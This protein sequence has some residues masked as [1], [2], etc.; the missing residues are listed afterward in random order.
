MQ[1]KLEQFS[2]T[3]STHSTPG[4]LSSKTGTGRTNSTF[5]SQIQR[6]LAIKKE[7]KGEH[8]SHLAGVRMGACHNANKLTGSSILMKAIE[9]SESQ[10]DDISSEPRRLSSNSSNSQGPLTPGIL[11][12]R[13]M[14][15]SQEDKNSYSLSS[16]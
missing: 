6:P 10:H 13:P 14:L 5:P 1:N 16:F 15:L 3:L 2:Q 9:S 8:F 11:G 12:K 7:S 4:P